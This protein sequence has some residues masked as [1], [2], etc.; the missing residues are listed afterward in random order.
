MAGSQL[1]GSR[2]SGECA[3]PALCF[4]PYVN[5]SRFDVEEEIVS[6]ES[7]TAHLSPAMA[8][9]PENCEMAPA[10]DRAEGLNRSSGSS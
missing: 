3:L 10:T 2:V 1:S 4:V 8:D 9:G 7:R 5:P 6:G